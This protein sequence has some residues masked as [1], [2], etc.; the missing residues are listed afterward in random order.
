MFKRFALGI[1][2]VIAALGVIFVGLDILDVAEDFRIYL[3]TPILD[4]A[5]ISAVAVP[6]TYIAARSFV[7]TGSRQMLWLGCGALAFGIG[8]LLREWLVVEE[9]NVPITLF[10]SAAL[11]A[12]VTHLIGASLSIAK[13]GTPKSESRRKIVL[14]YYLGILASISLVTLLTFRGLIPPFYVP[15]GSSTQLKDIVRGMT[16]FFFLASSFIYIVM[17][18]KLWNV[19]LYWY[20]LGLMLFAFGLISIFLG[21]NYSRI[22]WLGRASQ[23]VGSV[24]FLVA[25]LGAYRQASARNRE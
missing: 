22:I 1:F 6:V 8:V 9:L 2:L 3:P 14:F 16:T 21:E 19:F 17:Y 4:T 7:V 23:Y 25:V 20:S 18:Y 11:I 12:S 13:L 5:F 10:N 15:E 24:Y